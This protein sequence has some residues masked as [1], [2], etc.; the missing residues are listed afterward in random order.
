MRPWEF[1]QTW[2]LDLGMEPLNNWL[3]WSTVA[4]GPNKGN[5]VMTMVTPQ[6]HTPKREPEVGKPST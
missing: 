5:C 3:K 4:L 6:T 1:E 2:G